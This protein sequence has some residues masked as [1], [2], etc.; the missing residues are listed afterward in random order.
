MW[1]NKIMCKEIVCQETSSGVG[2]GEEPW[3][4]N[5]YGVSISIMAV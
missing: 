4:A 5:I 2:G 3:L 1:Y